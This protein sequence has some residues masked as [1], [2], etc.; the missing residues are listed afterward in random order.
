MDAKS[1]AALAALAFALFAVPAGNASAQSCV[2]DEDCS[3]GVW[4]NGIERCERNPGMGQCMPA[5]RPM[6][7]VKKVC[8]E[9]GK[10]CLKQEK[11]EQLLT[12]CPVGETFSATE[13]KCVAK[14]PR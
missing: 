5:P 14:P 12:P 7:S 3:D 4:C 6:C 9:A 2:T 8:D 10:R 1:L 13:N 11:V